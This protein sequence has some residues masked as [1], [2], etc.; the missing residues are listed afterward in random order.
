MNVEED[1]EVM[2]PRLVSG[3]NLHSETYSQRHSDLYFAFYHGRSTVLPR[4][5]VTE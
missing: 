1:V 2:R 5:A 3:V 4:R